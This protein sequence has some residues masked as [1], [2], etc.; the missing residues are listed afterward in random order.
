MIPLAGGTEDAYGVTAN[1]LGDADTGAN[2]LQNFPTITAVSANGSGVNL[3]GSLNS[4]PNSTFALD[5]YGNAQADP[6]GHGEGERYLGSAAVTTDGSGN[7]TFSV[8]LPGPVAS[9]EFITATATDAGTGSTSEFSRAMAIGTDTPPVPDMAT[10]STLTGECSVSVATRPTATD[11]QA[12]SITGTTTDPL[13]YDQQGIYAITWHYNDGHGNEATQP[14]TVIVKDTTAPVITI[15][16]ANPTTVE[17]HTSFSDPGATVLDN[18]AGSF[19]ASVAGS[20][21]V[22]TPGTYTLTYT[23]SDPSGNADVPVARTVNVVDT[24]KPV[25]MLTGDATLT[26]ECHGRF[27]DPGATANDTCAGTLAATT[28]GSVDANTPGTYTLTYTA[29]DPSGNAAVPVTRTVIVK[30][31]TPPTITCPADLTVACSLDPLVPVTFS[32][33][34]TDNCD[35]APAITYAPTSG[36]GF[37]IGTTTVTCTATDASGNPSS[38]PFNV[39]RAPLAF[40]GFLAPIGGADATGGGYASPVRTFKMGSTIPVKFTANCGVSPVL[41]GIH[42]LQVIN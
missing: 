28:A 26:V 19:A 24:A 36:S 20:V 1:D 34:A 8:T 33:T 21:D 31:T 17:C 7:A 35:P 25:I 14:Q 29:S 22:N 23:A 13:S 6:S 11:D 42:R 2:D 32:A 3:R 38:C 16:G 5:F 18:C 9:E 41:T 15:N 4:T 12:G 37:P 10:L 27:T 40:T 39:T 30:D